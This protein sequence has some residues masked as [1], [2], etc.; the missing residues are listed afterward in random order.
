MRRELKF[1]AWLETRAFNGKPMGFAYLDL[2]D[3]NENDFAIFPPKNIEQYTG[4]RDKNG[5]GI[6]EGDIVQIG[7]ER[8]SIVF[9]EKIG[10][11][12]GR[13]VADCKNKIV[14]YNDYIF[15]FCPDDIMIVGNIHE[16]PE[17]IGGEK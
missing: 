16:N 11:F 10:S 4:L 13:F 8:A 12:M 2:Y 9:D 3:D 15:D 7:G 1:R 6:Y 17:L 14:E 5:D